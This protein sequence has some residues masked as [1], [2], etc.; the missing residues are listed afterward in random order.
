VLGFT[1]PAPHC[2]SRRGTRRPRC[3]PTRGLLAASR[4][5]RGRSSFRCVVEPVLWIRVVDPWHFGMDPDPRI[6]CCGFITF[7]CGSGS[8]SGSADPCLWLMD[9]DPDPAIFVFDLQE[10]KLL[11]SSAYYFLKVHLHSF[12]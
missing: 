9:P 6:Q 5:S 3:G 12:S 8:V 10:A 7:C 11:S 2:W 4:W 1:S